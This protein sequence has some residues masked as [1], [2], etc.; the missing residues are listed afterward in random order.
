MWR[1]Y[2]ILDAITNVPNY[3]KK[4]L[5]ALAISKGAWRPRLLLQGQDVPSVDVAIVGCRE[6]LWVIL[7]TVKAALNTDYPDNRLRIIVSDDGVQQCVEIVVQQLQDRYLNRH[8][9]YTARAKS[10]ENSHEAGN[11]NHVLVFTATILGGHATFTAGPDA[12]MM[13]EIRWLRVQ[14]LHL[15]SDTRMEFTCPPP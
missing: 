5:D 14:L 11:L 10:P 4:L 2:I 6:E 7:D 3:F 15:I 12:D 13:P 1:T 9:F 8:L